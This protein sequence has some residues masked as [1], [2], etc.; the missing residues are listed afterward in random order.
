MV[1]T[2]VFCHGF[3]PCDDGEW[4]VE[5]EEVL[6]NYS[7]EEPDLATICAFCDQEQTTDRWSS[8][9]P[10]LLSGMKTSPMFVVW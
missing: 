1:S 4:K 8:E 5:L 6:G 2:M 3:W 9:I 10:E 7:S